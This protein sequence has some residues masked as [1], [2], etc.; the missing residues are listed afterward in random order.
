MSALTPEQ[1]QQALPLSAVAAAGGFGPAAVLSAAAELPAALAALKT[2]ALDV[3]EDYTALDSGETFTL[4]LH[5]VSSADVRV[6]ATVKA[7]VPKAAPEAPSLA[8]LFG[9]ADWYERE[10]FDMFGIRFAGHPD[11][12]RILLPE[13]WVG[14]PLRKDYTDDKLLKRPGA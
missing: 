8:G 10:I 13:D 4:V 3:C 11:L 1:L 14:Y 12:R 2:L 7:P 5:L 9:I 6:R